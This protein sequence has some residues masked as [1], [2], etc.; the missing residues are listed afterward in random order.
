MANRRTARGHA[1][2][3]RPA[4]I[5]ARLLDIRAVPAAPLAAESA[6]GEECGGEHEQP[7]VRIEIARVAT[8]DGA[9]WAAR[10]SLRSRLSVQLASGS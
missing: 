9:A 2:S 6:V 4:E 10:I 1:A 7:G 8:F 3:L 5:P